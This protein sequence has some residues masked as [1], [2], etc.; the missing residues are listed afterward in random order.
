MFYSLQEVILFRDMKISSL[1]IFFPAYNDSQ[2]IPKLIKTANSVAREIA[3]DYEIIVIND[4]SK[5]NTE[6]VVE[7]L[8]KKYKKLRVI[9]HSKNLGYGAA[10]ASGLSNSKKEWIFYTDGDGQYDPKELFLLLKSLNS[11]IDVVNGYKLRRS[12]N[13]VRK[14]L[15]N[16]YNFYLRLLYPIPVSDID[17]DFRLIRGSKIK[18][19]ELSSNGGSVCLELILKLQKNGARFAEVGVHHYRREHGHSQFFNIKNILKMVYENFNFYFKYYFS[20]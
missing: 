5:D 10:L 2:S 7:E 3:S 8:K 16:F 18:N 11:G 17:C 20:P 14:I 13:L 1:S 12:D 15:G 19:V 4:G 6:D 9:H